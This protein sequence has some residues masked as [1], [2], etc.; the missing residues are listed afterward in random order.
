MKLRKHI[1]K[2]VS[3][4]LITAMFFFAPSTLPSMIRWI[5]AVDAVTPRK[6]ALIFLTLN[7]GPQQPK[8]FAVIK[9]EQ[10]TA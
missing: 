7:H 8:N 2:I 9:Y 1:R 5:A 6:N 3:T 4:I 10:V